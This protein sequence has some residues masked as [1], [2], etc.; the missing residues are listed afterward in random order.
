MDANIVKNY[1]LYFFIEELL[2]NHPYLVDAIGG[3]LHNMS[4]AKQALHRKE[5]I[6]SLV[7]ALKRNHIQPEQLADISDF[8]D[9]SIQVAI[10][11][12]YGNV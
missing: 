5:V 6:S 2:T 8:I 10:Q 3:N 11:E 12:V 1:M 4:Q 7:E 9:Q